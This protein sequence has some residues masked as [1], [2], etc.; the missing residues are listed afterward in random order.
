M[1]NIDLR[2][3]DCA[4]VL[5]SMESCTIDLV[6]TSPPYDN[7][8]SYKGHGDSWTFDKFKD[9]ARELYRVVKEG[10][11]VV[12]VVGDATID[13]GESCTSFKQALYFVECGFKLFDTMIYEK[14]GCGACGSNNSYIQNFEYMF[15]LSKGEPKTT[16]LIYDRPNKITGARTTATNRNVHDADSGRKTRE[17][18][19]KPMGRRFNI[20]KY[21]QTQGHDEF[22]SKHPAPY[23]LPLAIDHIRSWSNEGDLVLDPFNGSGTTGVACVQLGRDYIGIDIEE[24]YLELARTRILGYQGITMVESKEGECSTFK[25]ESLF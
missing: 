8:R 7:L 6:V 9:I 18:V 11:M 2:L 20:W 14:S 22:S 24:S 19:A 17:V 10:G 21:N 4:E 25:K 1:S 5:G 13:G 16:N 15:V 3:G 12:W 23:P